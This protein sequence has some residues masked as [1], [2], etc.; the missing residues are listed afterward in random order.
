MAVTLVEIAAV[1]AMVVGLLLIPLGV[2]GLWVMIAALAVAVLAG[3]AVAWGTVLVLAVVAGV[4]ELGEY[5]AV[6]LAS[7]RWG[8]SSRAF[9]GAIAGGIVGAMAG[10]PVPVVGS[11]IGILLGTFAGAV[12]AAWLESRDAREAVQVGWGAVLGRAAA[13]AVKTGAGLA[14]LLVAVGSF[15]LW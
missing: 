8:G 10:T 6:R 13:T 4:A 5:V 14:I 2:P 7:D 9:W 3:S 11:L 1:A 15:W 12:L